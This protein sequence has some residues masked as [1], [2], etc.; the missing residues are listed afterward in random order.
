LQIVAAVIVVSV[1][2][3]DAIL[4]PPG[5]S[6]LIAG[7]LVFSVGNLIR[8]TARRTLGSN[9]STQVEIRP[10]QKVMRNGIYAWLRHPAYLGLCIEMIGYPVALGSTKALIISVLLFIPTVLV[11]L[12]LEDRVL[13][14]RLAGYADYRQSTPALFPI[15]R[16]E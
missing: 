14:E 6:I 9:W 13:T 11:R 7:C 8:S 12:W 15:F 2:W 16:Q 3:Y 5:I 4:R 1:S 10:D